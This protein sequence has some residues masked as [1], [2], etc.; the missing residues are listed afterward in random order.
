MNEEIIYGRPVVSSWRHEI[1]RLLIGR[2]SSCPGG[3]LIRALFKTMWSGNY[4]LGGWSAAAA[5]AAAAGNT[6][7][8]RR[9]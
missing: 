7:E 1:A 4:V 6:R 2:F 5:A 9:R 3:S 8:W